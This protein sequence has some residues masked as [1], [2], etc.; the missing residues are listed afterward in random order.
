L[1]KIILSS[2]GSYPRVGEGG[3]GQRLRKAH[4]EFEQGKR[5]GAELKETEREL[6]SEVIALQA[7]AGLE[8][9]TDGQ[10][11][12][13]DPISHF[14]GKAEGV[15]VG[16][17]SRFFDTNFYY[18]QPI[19][20]ER[21]K[22]KAPIVLDEFLFAR[23]VSPLPVKPVVTGAYTLGRLSVDRHYNDFP[24]LVEDIAQVIAR[25]VELL[26]QQGA[27]VI[28]IDEPAIATNREDI[29][30]LRKELDLIAKDKGSAR[31]ALY[32]YFGDTA[33]I[34]QELQ[35]LPIDILGLDFTY[36]PKLAEVIASVEN[37]KV[38]GLGLID[39]RN[40]KMESEQDILPVLRQIMPAIG[41]GDCYLNPSC[42]LEYLTWERAFHKLENMKRLRDKFVEGQK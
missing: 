1:A 37:K 27:E 41:A 5:T 30:L 9:V 15:E 26:A 18:R 31:L 24:Q 13:Y 14:L 10:I 21:V 11:G 39:G 22:W 38:L 20:V 34:Y 4:A 3:H 8:L 42:G 32:T 33:G 7:K 12:W 16:G 17:L 36:S 23:S 28:Q 25:E 19:I 6:T 35:S 29:L 40:T 2:S